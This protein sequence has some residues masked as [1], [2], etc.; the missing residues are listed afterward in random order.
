MKSYCSSIAS[1]YSY[2]INEFFHSLSHKMEVEFL[3][4]KSSSLRRG[5]FDPFHYIIYDL[6]SSLLWHNSSK[7]KYRIFNRLNGRRTR[8]VGIGIVKPIAW[9]KEIVC[10][11]IGQR[12]FL[13]A[14]FE[15]YW[16]LNIFNMQRICN[17]QETEHLNYGDVNR[18][19]LMMCY[20]FGNQQWKSTGLD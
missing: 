15:I 6:D 18:V 4:P 19:Q 9:W 3:A 12:L 17:R 2:H 10:I 13:S 7:W 8:I 11:V 16:K 20:N 1:C 14:L 5:N